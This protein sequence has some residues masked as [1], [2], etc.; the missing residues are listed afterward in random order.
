[1]YIAIAFVYLNLQTTERI[2]KYA[3]LNPNAQRD[4]ALEKLKGFGFISYLVITVFQ[5]VAYP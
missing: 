5:C 1:L 4:D 2:C 3:F